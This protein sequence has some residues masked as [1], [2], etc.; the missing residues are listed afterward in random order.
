METLTHFW[1]ILTWRTVV[2]VALSLGATR[3]CLAN[4]ITAELPTTLIGIAVVF[5]I[6]FSINSA[7]R[8][9]EEA[10]KSLA[11]IKANIAALGFMSRDWTPKTSGK[12]DPVIEELAP[13]LFGSIKESLA[14]FTQENFNKVYIVLS[15]WSAHHE[16]LREDGISGSEISRANQYLRTIM[17]DFEN[18][19]N[20][21]RYRTPLNLRAYSK[22]F[23]HV[24]PITFAPHFAFMMQDGGSLYS[25]YVV[26]FFYSLVFVCLD[27]I[28][29]QLENPFDQNGI[30]DVRLDVTERYTPVLSMEEDLKIENA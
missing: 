3:L 12:T 5:P 26:A 1:S 21:A 23:L 25:G 13:D 10:I 9:R 16:V 4:S 19:R 18:M 8:R 11:S 30:D 7:Y 6:V 20:I 17:T 2:V 15:K 28:Q 14:N 27:V 22:V 24:I 29:E